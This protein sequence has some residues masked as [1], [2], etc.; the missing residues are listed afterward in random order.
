MQSI[1]S[2]T[3]YLL[4]ASL[5][6]L[7]LAVVCIVLSAAIGVAAGVLCAVTSRAVEALILAVV[8]VLRGVPVL[9]QLFLVYFGL[10]F[11]GIIANPYVVAIVA[12]S[13]HMGALVTEVVRGSIVSL[14]AA[15]TEGGLALGLMPRQ[16]AWKVL[17]P[18]ALV[19]A[20]PPYVSLIPVTIKATA[21]ASVI[22]IWELTLASKEIAAQTLDTFHTFGYAF[23]L[24]FVLCYPFT[25]VGRRLERRAAAFHR[26]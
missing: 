11:F 18:Q 13:L 9:V 15:Q 25:M 20:M 17:L 22:N 10:P 23:A 14:P 1:A 16:V 8:Y 21:L 2:A 4:Q 6:T 5:T 26:S 7:W 19:A 24:Y 12:I 3:P